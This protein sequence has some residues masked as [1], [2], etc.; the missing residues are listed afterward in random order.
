MFKQTILDNQELL[1]HIQIKKRDYVFY[2]DLLKIKKIV[3]F[4]GPRRVGKTYLMMQFVKEL[5]QKDIIN[6]EQVVMI[7]LALYED[8]KLDPDKLL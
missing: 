8:K 6:R 3:S 2:E 7:D 4:V 5:I 1:K